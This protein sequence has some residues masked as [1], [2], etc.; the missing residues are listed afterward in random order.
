MPTKINIYSHYI[1]TTLL[2]N[3]ASRFEWML[4]N[5]RIKKIIS[6][7]IWATFFFVFVFFEVSALL[8]V[9]H[10][11]KLQSCEITRKTNDATLTK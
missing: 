5:I 9:R 11:P 1:D 7:L 8:D 6:T 2:E 10:C 4:A 3:R